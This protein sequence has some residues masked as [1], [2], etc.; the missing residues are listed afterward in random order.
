MRIFTFLESYKRNLDFNSLGTSESH[1]IIEIILDIFKNKRTPFEVS[2]NE[3]YDQCSSIA[4]S[5]NMDTKSRFSK[6][7]KTK[8]ALSNQLTRFSEFFRNS[9]Y[10]VLI[11]RHDTRDKKFK[12]GTSIISV[13]STSTLFQSNL[14]IK[15]SSLSSLSACQDEKQ[16]Q[17]KAKIDKDKK[18]VSLSS[19]SACQDEKQAQNKAKIDK[20]DDKDETKKNNVSLSKNTESRHKKDDWQ[21]DKDDKGDM[22]TQRVS[23]K[24]KIKSYNRKKKSSKSFFCKDCNFDNFINLDSKSI[25][26]KT[27]TIYNLHKKANPNHNVEFSDGVIP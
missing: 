4:Y 8:Q 13:T 11:K 18:K 2:V 27:I 1:P 17:N 6:F 23:T 9:G 24:N 10:E 7:P 15:E 19:L 22:P 3:V 12:R 16:A 26:D 5:K 25:L 20:D 14:G 21:G